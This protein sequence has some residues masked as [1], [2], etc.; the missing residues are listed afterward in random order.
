[1]KGIASGSI[2]YKD[3]AGTPLKQMVALQI[4]DGAFVEVARPTPA[5]VP[6]P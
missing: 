3:Q 2:T 4:K 1:M 6:A 5:W